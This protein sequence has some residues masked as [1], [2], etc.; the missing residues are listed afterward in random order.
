[1]SSFKGSPS[2]CPEVY[3][4]P[5]SIAFTPHVF[6][7]IAY[8][9]WKMPFLIII[10]TSL[11]LYYICLW[12]NSPDGPN[13]LSVTVSLTPYNLAPFFCKWTPR[14]LHMERGQLEGSMSGGKANSVLMCW[15]WP[16][17]PHK[18]QYFC[19]VAEVVECLPSKYEVLSSKYYHQKKKR[20]KKW[21]S[22]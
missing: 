20:K 6:W 4:F 22:S 17:P 3:F 2:L 16:L 1:M 13:S 15:W 9:P 12:S 11:S 19:I 7:Y 18:N 14:G 10:S 8:Q 21:A 5:K